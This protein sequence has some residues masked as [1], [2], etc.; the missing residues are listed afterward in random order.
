MNAYERMAEKST[1]SLSVLVFQG[2]Y[3]VAAALAAFVPGQAAGASLR[4]DSSP[5]MASE[6]YDASPNSS[7]ASPSSVW[8]GSDVVRE[9]I[10]FEAAVSDFYSNLLQKQEPLGDMFSKVLSDNLWDLYARA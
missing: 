7:S 9:S 4:R 1:M 8:G 3:G 2:S 5:A 10:S 6:G